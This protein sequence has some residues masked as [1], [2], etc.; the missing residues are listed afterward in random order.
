MSI[1]LKI[2]SKHLSVEAEIIRHEER[3]QLH[4]VRYKLNEIRSTG[5]NRDLNFEAAT[6]LSSYFNLRQH[7]KWDVRNEARATHLARAFL[8]NK[9]YNDVEMKR[10]PGNEYAFSLIIPRIV[11]MVNKYGNEVVTTEEIKKWCDA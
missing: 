2:K 10:K 7:R 6:M 9:P 3:K 5:A 11:A 4:H 8:S 1:E